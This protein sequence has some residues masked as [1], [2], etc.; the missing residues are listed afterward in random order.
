MGISLTAVQSKP[1]SVVAGM[2]VATVVSGDT[3]VA[4]TVS[5]AVSS[6]VGVAPPQ[7]DMAHKKSK[8]N[9]NFKVMRD[10]VSSQ[11]EKTTFCLIFKFY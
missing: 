6:S 5:T 10:I 1:L 9:N 3:A 8:T 4:A 7:P 11:A 2:G